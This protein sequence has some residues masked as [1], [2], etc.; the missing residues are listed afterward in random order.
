MEV[1][2]KRGLLEAMLGFAREQHPHEVVVLLRGGVKRDVLSI[3]DFLVPPFAVGGPG[4]AAFPLHMLPIDFSI[5]GAAHSHPSGALRPS[6][7]DL[8]HLYSRV[9]II[10]AY[11]YTPKRTAA[12]NARG[13]RLPIRVEG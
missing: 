2:I 8:N 4:F 13:E 5:I 7:V 9:M 12:F 1:S 10:L 3:D 11:P 6:V